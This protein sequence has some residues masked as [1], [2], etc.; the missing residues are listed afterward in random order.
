MAAADS[1]VVLLSLMFNG[2]RQNFF[3]LITSHHD[4]LEKKIFWK[5]IKQSPIFNWEPPCQACPA[6]QQVAL[7]NSLSL[8]TRGGPA[9]LQKRCNNYF[10]KTFF[11]QISW[12]CSDVPWRCSCHKVPLDGATDFLATI[13]QHIITVSF[14][15]N[16][17]LSKHQEVSSY[18]VTKVKKSVYLGPSWCNKKVNPETYVPCGSY[19]LLWS[20][21]AHEM[22]EKLTI[23]NKFSIF[24]VKF[25][26]NLKFVP[27]WAT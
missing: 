10:T 19:E 2:I 25:H 3:L 24:K 6:K 11:L 12:Y 5:Q 4:V 16:Q 13:W 18:P 22:K 20:N 9:W 26:W 7:E 15:V 27:F 8:H 1:A 21:L 23:Q 14:F 17:G